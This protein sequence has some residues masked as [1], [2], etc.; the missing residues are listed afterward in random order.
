MTS[1][2]IQRRIE[3]LLDEADA[4]LVER[5]WA[6]ILDLA[7][8]VLALD[9]DN[10]DALTFSAA[11]GRS[12]GNSLAESIAPSQA[13]RTTPDLP[14]AP[15][16]VPASFAGGRYAVKEFLG[17][18]GKKRVY[19]AH[20]SVLDRD[21]ALA[22][23]KTEGLDPTSRVRV[24]REAQAMGRLDDH[25]HVLSIH[26]L[27][28]EAGQPYMVLPLMP[29]GDVGT[30]LEAAEDHR[31]PL[32]QAI[33]LA[34]QICRG[35]E[36]AHSKGIVHRD[37]KPGNIWL[38]AD[39]TARI[40]DFRLAV[41]NDRSRLTQE[42]TIAGTVSYMPPEP[43]MGGDVTPQSDLYSLGAMLYE[44]VTG[45]PPFLG[46]DSVAIIGQHINTPPV[47]PTWHNSEC[48]RTLEA[49]IMRLLAKDPKERP[50]S[51]TDAVTALEAIDLTV[52][53]EEETSERD[54]AHAL[55]SLESSGEFRFRDGQEMELKGLAGTHQVFEVSLL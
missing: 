16:A 37:L 3:N 11:A 47:A 5:D 17:E 35:L 21:V 14:T 20:D 10:A 25:P 45:R 26:D 29:G 27:G 4:A 24:T 8:T 34:A 39:G 55:D 13:V 41:A 50:D 49:L 15:T 48:P 1:E 32:E 54:E 33:D 19:R 46:D 30:L 31:L 40:G 28:D 12:V 36:F 51:A 6:T 22:V 52:S 38:T 2:R 23:I 18:G 44:M 53:A 43:A 7:Q 9:P 42:G